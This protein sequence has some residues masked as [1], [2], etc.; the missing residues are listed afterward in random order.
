MIKQNATKK[1]EAKKNFCTFA[2]KLYVL[3]YLCL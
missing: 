1:K 2:Q 3:K